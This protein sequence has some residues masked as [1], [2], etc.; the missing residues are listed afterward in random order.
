MTDNNREYWANLFNY[1]GRI[2]RST[3]EQLAKDLEERIIA[4]FDWRFGVKEPTELQ[5]F[6]FWL[7]AKCLDA[8]WRLDA[9]SK[10]LDVCELDDVSIAIQ[11]EALCELLPDHTGKVLEVLCQADR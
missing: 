11:V 4:F 7:E 2:L 1:V 3:S 6:T 9:Y 8:E 10:I 5:Q